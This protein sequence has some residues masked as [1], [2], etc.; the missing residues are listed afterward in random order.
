MWSC[1]HVVLSWS[2]GPVVMWSC[3]PVS[4]GPVVMWSCRH[5]V[6]SSGHVVRG[7]H[8]LN[9]VVWQQPERL[10]H[11]AHEP[12]D[13][14]LSGPRAPREAPVEADSAGQV[15]AAPLSKGTTTRSSRHLFNHCRE[16][17]QE[18]PS[19]TAM[20][21]MYIYICVELYKQALGD[22]NCS[23]SCHLACQI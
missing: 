12:G 5:V 11:A 21:Y 13:G 4:C 14:R 9:G 19:L 10:E 20:H 8:L 1:G 17:Q 16:Q 2:C 6:L 22:R 15:L 18:I 3:G 23:Y 7:R